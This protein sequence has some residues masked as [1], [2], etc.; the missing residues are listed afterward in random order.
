MKHSDWKRRWTAALLACTL[1]L[2][3]W[4]VHAIPSE[5]A[6]P[7]KLVILG[8]TVQSD[9]PPMIVQGRTLVP[10][11][12][13]SQKLKAKVDWD[14]S[15][16]TAIVQYDGHTI[17][18]TYGAKYYIFDGE[19]KTLDVN[20]RLVNGRVLVPLRVI[21]Q[22]FGYKVDWQNASRTVVISAKAPAAA[23]TPAAQEERA[24]APM[25]KAASGVAVVTSEGALI[26]DRVGEGAIGLFAAKIGDRY[27]VTAEVE[28]W[29]KINLPDGRSGFLAKKEARL[30]GAKA[31]SPAT[32][33]VPAAAP[34]AALDTAKAGSTVAISEE[35]V[36]LRS[37][38]GTDYDRLTSL[39]RGE[40]LTVIGQASGWYQVKTSA[41]MTAWVRGDLVADPSQ[42]EASAPAAQMASSEASAP[43][44]PKEPNPV[45]YVATDT[46]VR[47]QAKLSF[48]V[49]DSP[50]KVIS[51][52]D[53]RVKI[54]IEGARLGPQSATSHPPA[55]FQSFSMTQDGP[56][57]VLVT[58]SVAG[59]N[60]FRVDRTGTT[61]ALTAVAK[62]KNGNKGL[63]GK[64]IVI[65]PGHGNISGNGYDPGAIGT[66]YG[67]SEVMF[68]TPTA[69]KLKRKLELAGARVIMTRPDETPIRLTLKERADIANRNNADAFVEIHGNSAPG[70][71]AARGIG[72]YLYDGP[73]RLT[74]AA[75]KTMRH[76]FANDLRTGLAAATG[77]MTYVRV[78]NF[79]VT[80]ENE[81]PSVLIECGFL[82]NPEEEALLRS[83]TY[84][85]KL[86]QGMFDGLR[87]YFSY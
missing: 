58:A 29:L 35:V 38:P 69:Q 26:R 79:A 76:R 77:T 78:D 65:S 64:T 67:T 16:Q 23:P 72:V 86:A 14:Q 50:A 55:P 82:T 40:R 49:G 27:D 25:L 41:G 60:Y 19:V 59:G 44:P 2:S 9:V 39:P 1:A 28:D 70:N 80:R 36:N 37:G 52:G 15:S 32:Q 71:P 22:S 5:A 11:R 8:Q 84:Q 75:Q 12:I 68:N 74:S 13:I 56:R 18:L 62:H 21:S 85:E 63:A 61:F 43:E 24:A 47:G 45:Q 46:S 48:R 54:R 57:N 6:P 66:T 3:G 51:E 83:D 87:R 10:V 53:G 34:K 33:A 42:V 17:L 20:I 31:P 73:L 81:V 7:V 4:A 30:E